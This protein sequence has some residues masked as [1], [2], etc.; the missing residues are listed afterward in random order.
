MKNIFLIL[1]FC[2]NTAIAQ[3]FNFKVF[4]TYNGLSNNN[5]TC[6]QK[7]KN[8][9]IW[10]G[11]QNG[12]NRFDGNAFDVFYNNPTDTN[13]IGNNYIQSVFI[14]STNKLWVG[15]ASGLSTYNSTTQQFYNYAPDTLVMPKIGQTFP[16]INED[17]NKNIWV[18]SW[19]DLLIFNHTTQKF[20]SSGWANYVAK[21]R[22]ANGN[23]RRVVVLSIVAK[24]DTAFWVQTTYGLFSV[25]TISLQFNYHP[26]QNISD[27]YGSSISYVDENKNLWISTY[28]KG[29]LF[30]NT[31]TNT[32]KNYTIP[33]HFLKRTEWNN[34]N[35]IKSYNA[36]TLI[37]CSNKY[38]LLF[39][40]KREMFVTLV[41]SNLPKN[42]SLTQ[43]IQFENII[44]DDNLFWLLSGN[45]LVR[46]T[47]K[48][49]D[50]TFNEVSKLNFVNKLFYSTST[51]NFVIGDFYTTSIFYNPSTKKSKRVNTNPAAIENGVR[52][53]TEINKDTAY[54][55]TDQNWYQINPTTLDCKELQLPPKNFKDNPNTIRNIVVDNN[56]NL[57]IRFRAQG[58]Y[59]YNPTNNKGEYAKFIF[60]E[61]SKEYAALYFDSLSNTIFTAVP[62]EG[63]YMYSITKNTTQKYLLNI[64]P[65]QRGANINCITGNN[66][67][68]VFFADVYNGLFVFN[69]STHQFKRY[70]VYE[71]LPSN[72]INWLT[73]DATGYLWIATNNGI[74]CFNYNAQQFSNYGQQQGD[75]GYTDFLT[76]DYKG[77]IY[78][79]YQKG[80]Y[81][82]NATTLLQ[83]KFLGKIYLRHCTLNDKNIAI[84]SIYNFTST[85]NNIS[86]QFGYL[87]ENNDDDVRFEYNL[88]GG[89]W[90][91]INNSNKLS[92][93]NLSPN[94]YVLQVKEKST[95]NNVFTIYFIIHPPFYKKWWFITLAILLAIS[96][97][98]FLLKNRI[99]SIKKQATLKQQIAETEMMALRAQMNPHFIFNAISSIDNFILDNDATNASNYLNKFA[100]L[101]RNILDNSKN[102]VVP[103][104]KDWETLSLYLQLEQL[105]S[106]DSFTYTL[107]ADEKLLNGHYKIPPLIIQPYIENAIHHGL[108]PLQNKKGELT[109]AA[110]INNNTLQYTITDNGIG[111]KK[112]AENRMVKSQHQSYGMQLTQQR[113]DLFNNQQENNV[114]IQDIENGN[115]TGTIVT[116]FLKV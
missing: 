73:I 19:Y 52:A 43:Q 12:L 36:D 6:L 102:D 104:W 3:Q 35:G 23:H 115:N 63:I 59:K 39:D 65:S 45:G 10:V 61:Q 107:H 62:N 81:S 103:F 77:N 38:L 97:F 111:R 42:N 85:Q 72:N 86:F 55:C 75:F 8:N 56:K 15:T 29:I 1:L 106:N 22:P 11:T 20:K 44:K 68:L 95:A 87:V 48:K 34:A 71:G 80:Y 110:T 82:W 26:Y 112:A 70:T 109:I 74:S 7:D 33:P 57:W 98:Y 114:T 32:W 47:N 83:P 90:L 113:I 88:N 25:N 5:I 37:V 96:V 91:S 67:G 108:K 89:N 50:F 9:F 69:S 41:S 84:D 49:N 116:V 2:A 58:I 100:K 27:Y 40:R 54:L 18:G 101:I 16:C 99:K 78:R 53:Y 30:Y 66:E 13:T 17:A 51:N 14:S 79:P 92:F 64:P 4:N 31:H 21:I 76:S 60:P 93:S 105:R 94:K 24:N 28:D 46:L